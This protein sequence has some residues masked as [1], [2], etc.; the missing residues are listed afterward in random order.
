MAIRPQPVPAGYSRTARGSRWWVI[1][2]T[3]AVAM[4]LT[5]VP[6]PDWMRFAVPHWV[7][8][9][10]FYWCLAVPDRIGVGTGWLVGLVMDL[11]L[12]TLFGVYAM[13]QAFVALVA[14]TFHR[15]VRMYPLWQQCI[16]LLL[17]CVVEIT[18][19]AWV[20]QL[21]NDVGLR[22]I[23]WQAALTTALVW[24][25]VYTVLRFVRQRSGIVQMR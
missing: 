19:V 4:L 3:L 7:S 25:V 11:L 17:V 12:H 10:L 5:M 20:F 23:Y 9:V 24:P 18:F 8:L 1:P 22:L 6:Y 14:I 16:V 2:A 13:T 21:T 15:R